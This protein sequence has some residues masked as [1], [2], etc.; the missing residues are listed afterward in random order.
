MLDHHRVREPRVAAAQ[1]LGDVRVGDG[2]ALDVGLVDHRLVVGDARVPVAAPV[3]ERVDDHGLRHERRRVGVVA[4]VRAAEGVAEHRLVPLH[5]PVEGLRVG[6][7]QQLVRVAAQALGG[8]VR[9]VHP[10]PVTLPRLHRRQVAVPDEAVDLAERDARLG[11]RL[12]EQT[13]LD[14]FG[15]LGE[16]REVRAR[17]VV[18]R[19][20]RV[21]ATR[22]RPHQ[23]PISRPEPCR[24]CSVC[25]CCGHGRAPSA[26]GSARQVPAVGPGKRYRGH[27]ERWRRPRRSPPH[28]VRFRGHDHRVQPHRR[29]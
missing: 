20:Q 29:R 21:G 3:E 12:V 2:E 27:P 8:V 9:T 15:H 24:R 10:V 26:S 11:A 28:G 13:Q 18:A 16:D 5:R 6:V 19:A 22:P 7:D 23:T 25:P 1:L 14:A 4:L 17:A